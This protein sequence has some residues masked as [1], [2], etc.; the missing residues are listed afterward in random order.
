VRCEC[1]GACAAITDD[2]LLTDP[3]DQAPT[4]WTA[5]SR[6]RRSPNQM[7]R[8][9]RVRRRV[10][11][12]SQEHIVEESDAAQLHDAYRYSLYDL[13]WSTPMSTLAKDFGIS[14]VALAKR[15][16]AVDVPVP[17]RGY[18]THRGAGRHCQISV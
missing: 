18:W 1:T 4:G 14:V 8:A 3:Q 5:S 12:R 15:C 11:L 6:G 7:P 2:R 10:D 9:A 17:L 13:V 16:R